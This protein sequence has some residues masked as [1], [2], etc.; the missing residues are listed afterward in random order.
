MHMQDPKAG[1]NKYDTNCTLLSTQVVGSSFLQALVLCTQDIPTIKTT[2]IVLNLENFPYRCH[3]YVLVPSY[4]IQPQQNDQQPLTLILVTYSP[5]TSDKLT[6]MTT[7]L[8]RLPTQT[9]TTQYKYIGIGK[10]ICVQYIV[11]T[12]VGGQCGCAEV[13]GSYTLLLYVGSQ[14]S[15][16]K[17]AFTYKYLVLLI[18]S[19]CLVN[20]LRSF[21]K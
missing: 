20:S 14:C 1:Y 8:V 10:I 17:C 13:A 19:K 11:V 6:A 2:H 18:S 21:R 9:Y 16:P 5:V 4:Y 12:A 7:Y 15:V 3:S